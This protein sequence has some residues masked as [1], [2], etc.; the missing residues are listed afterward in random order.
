MGKIWLVAMRELQAYFR[1]W[2]GYVVASI[3]LL[4]TGLLFNAFAIGD[5]PKY[6][7]DILADFFYFN[8]GITMVASVFIAMRLLAEEKQSGTIVLFFTSPITERQFVYG[9][10]LS[11]FIFGLFLQ[12]LSL[13]LPALILLE[14]KVSLG[15]LAAGYLGVT[16]LGTAVLAMCLFASVLAPSQMV[17]GILGAAV[18]VGALILWLLSGVVD[19]PFRELFSYLAIHNQHFTPFSKGIVHTMDLVFYISVAFFFLECSI[20]VLEA[21]RVQG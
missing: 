11:A 4:M 21:R 7:S 9:K 6:S 14:G 10:F 12:V 15:H 13:Y 8:S 19:E 20:R 1:T 2:T 16:L 17:A 5:N 18:T 3:S